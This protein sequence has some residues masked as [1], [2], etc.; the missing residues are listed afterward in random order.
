MRC[1]RLS[2]GRLLAEEREGVFHVFHPDGLLERSFLSGAGSERE[3]LTSTAY[4]VDGGELRSRFSDENTDMPEELPTVKIE[5]ELSGLKPVEHPGV[6]EMIASAMAVREVRVKAAAE[7]EAE[8]LAAF[9]R[10]LP[11]FEGERDLEF[12][13]AYDPQGAIVVRGP[14]RLEVWREAGYPNQGRF[15]FAQLDDILR[16]RYKK[17]LRSFTPDLPDMRSAMAFNP[18]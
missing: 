3:H 14:G 18:E 11:E 6:E 8:K 15:R 10:G 2:D 7:R 17:R 4:F 16:R 5:I 12:V 1:W 9:E 13:F